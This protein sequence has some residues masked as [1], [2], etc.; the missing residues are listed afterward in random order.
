MPSKRDQIRNAAADFL[1][2]VGEPMHNTK[3][4]EAV[5]PSLGLAESV[6]PKD[7]NT[8]LHDDPQ[9]RFARVAKGTWILK[10][11]VRR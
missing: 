2:R 8:C 4:A 11:E 7:V 9:N 10:S 6:T 3:I 5:L 1:R